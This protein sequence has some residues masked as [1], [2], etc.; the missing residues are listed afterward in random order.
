MYPSYD[1]ILLRQKFIQEI[2]SKERTVTEVA[3]LLSVSR[4]MVH[5]WIARYRYEGLDGLVPRKSGPK[6]GEAKNR[7]SEDTENLVEEIAKRFPFDGPVALQEKLEEDYGIS[8]HQATIY[9]ILKR[10]K[11]RYFLGYHHLKKKKKS[12]VL[13]I[14]GQEIQMDVCFP[15]G[16]QRDLA[17][18]SLIDDCSRYVFSRAYFFHTQESTMDFMRQA[19]HALPFLVMAVRTD[20]GREFGKIFTEFLEKHNMEH[21]K[22][23]PYTPEHNGKI[24]RYHR[25][26]KEKEACHW[27][28]DSSLQELNY[29]LFLW[30]SYYNL[31]RKHTG[32]G[33]NKRTPFQKIYETMI[34]SS[35]QAQ[36]R[37][38]NWTLQQNIY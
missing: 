18:Y 15:F 19:V 14:P 38:G 26:F 23:P 36:H 17:I 21:R 1:M 28:F 29:R 2:E 37:S 27:Y 16:Y 8:L 5:K 30:T 3:K 12:Y 11:V 9:R 13:E 33:M 34:Q 10:R 4:R 6:T 7:T 35:L 32:L 20:Q 22:N 25:T 31:K 24:E